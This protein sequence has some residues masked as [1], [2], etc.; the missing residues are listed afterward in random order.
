MR[1]K[2][3]ADTENIELDDP[4]IIAPPEPPPEEPPTKREFNLTMKPTL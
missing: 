2:A 1:D 4:N 3:T